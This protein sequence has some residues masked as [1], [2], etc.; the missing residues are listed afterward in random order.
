MDGRHSAPFASLK[1]ESVAAV[2]HLLLRE[3]KVMRQW[4]YQA[5]CFLAQENNVLCAVGALAPVDWH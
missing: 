3:R 4:R 1:I 2:V 5:P